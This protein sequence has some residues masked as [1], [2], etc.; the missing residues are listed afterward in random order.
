[1]NEDSRLTKGLAHSRDQRP[2]SVECKVRGE[3]KAVGKALALL[4]Q[5]LLHHFPFGVRVKETLED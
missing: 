5:D 4:L 1:M 3:R 2:G